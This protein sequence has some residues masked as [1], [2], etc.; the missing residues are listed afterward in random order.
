M[1]N[2]LL[3]LF[4]VVAI[5]VNGQDLSRDRG[6]LKVSEYF[7]YYAGVAGDTCGT[8]QDTM[9]YKWFVNKERALL[10][11]WNV[12]VTEKRGRGLLTI[13]LQGR[14]FSTESWTNIT[15]TT[16]Y[17]GG[18]DTTVKFSQQ[19]TASAVFYNHFR[20]YLTKANTLGAVNLNFIT[21]SLKL[22]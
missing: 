17:G 10:Y 15:S 21:G 20:V 7:P 18:T 16:Y 13:S 3:F 4:A 9:E 8:T 12:K 22:Q 2:I 14:N 11:D 1:R 6:G 19:T 5:A